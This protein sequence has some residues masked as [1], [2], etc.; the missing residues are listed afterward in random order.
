M[1]SGQNN[2]SASYAKCLYAMTPEAQRQAAEAAQE[3]MRAAKL[4]KGKEPS[5]QPKPT[6]TCRKR[7]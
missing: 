1:G 7:A 2:Y 3:A 5:E 6:S 4:P